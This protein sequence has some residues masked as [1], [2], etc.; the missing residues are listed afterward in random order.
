MTD[1]LEN[2]HC[3]PTTI[4]TIKKLE[5]LDN[6][7]KSAYAALNAVDHELNE[8]YP[9]KMSGD[10]SQDPSIQ[11]F[12]VY[13]A[14]T[15]LNILREQGYNVREKGALFTE[16]W[17]QEH[18]KFS[19]MDQHIHP[20]GTQIVGFYFL[21]TPESSCVATFHDPRPGKAQLGISENDTLNVTYASNAFHFQPEPG[22][23]I[24]TNAW[25]PHSFTKNGNTEPF[26]FVHFNISLVDN[27]QPA[28]EVE[29]I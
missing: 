19:Q 24:L 26:R 20:N 25:L 6:V 18:H 21:D 7:R 23:L 11:D 2:I 13:T 16:M 12:C 27:P 1:V 15:A 9:V 22:V 8:I 3:F 4:Y 5:F 10:I 14:V 17:C 29:I 28:C